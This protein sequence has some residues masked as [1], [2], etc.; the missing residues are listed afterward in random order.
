MV[1]LLRGQDETFEIIVGTV[2][3]LAEEI[4]EEMP[5]LIMDPGISTMGLLVE[6]LGVIKDLFLLRMEEIFET[7]QD[8]EISEPNQVQKSYRGGIIEVT[9]QTETLGLPP[10]S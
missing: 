4:S 8:L 7:I 9:V 1:L 10:I 5:R 3:L 2:H 6:I